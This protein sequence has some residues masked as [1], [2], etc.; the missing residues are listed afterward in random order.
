M[1]GDNWIHGS[2]A[3]QAS[4]LTFA[5]GL[6]KITSS[7]AALAQLKADGSDEDGDILSKLKF[8]VV[9]VKQLE[10]E[11]FCACDRHSNQKN[12]ELITSK[13]VPHYIQVLRQT[14]PSSVDEETTKLYNKTGSG[15]HKQ[16]WGK[17][18]ETDI[19]AEAKA[20]FTPKAL[21][22]ITD[23][24]KLNSALFYYQT[25]IRKNYQ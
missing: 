1:G 3:A 7:G 18:E 23:L 2:G 9:K 20:T 13:H 16:L 10:T 4:K 8:A 24:K 6:V 19:L 5:T 22:S 17:F 12:E 15:W 14:S 25:Q 11:T 21:K